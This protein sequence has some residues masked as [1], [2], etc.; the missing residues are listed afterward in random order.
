VEGRPWI[1][2]QSRR[3]LVHEVG[4]NYGWGVC[5]ACAI[6]VLG[7]LHIRMHRQPPPAPTSVATTLETS[8]AVV[9]E[10]RAIGVEETCY[11]PI[12]FLVLPQRLHVLARMY[13]PIRHRQWAEPSLS[14]AMHGS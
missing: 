5:F 14:L 6:P 8:K 1:P 4:D 9:H 3:K 7:A 13:K 12:L 11:V 2:R 10:L